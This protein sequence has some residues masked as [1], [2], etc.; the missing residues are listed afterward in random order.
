M[1]MPAAASI[2]PNAD[3]GDGRRYA[4]SHRASILEGSGQ[5][6]MASCYWQPQRLASGGQFDPKAMTAA[7]KTLPFG[8]RV[9][10]KHLHNGRSVD[11]LIIDRG[12]TPLVASLTSAGQ[13]PIK[14]V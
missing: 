1:S 3:A 8:A 10:V 14:S 9:R 6:G 11:V 12:P 2:N 4:R 13:Q 5:I 7:H